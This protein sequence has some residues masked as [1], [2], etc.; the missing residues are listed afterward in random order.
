MRRVGA[1]EIGGQSWAGGEEQG[2][3][4]GS[5][6]ETTSGH[7]GLGVSGRA[8]IAAIITEGCARAPEPPPSR[9]VGCRSAGYFCIALTSHWA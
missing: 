9:R 5:Y 7:G 6:E 2:A 8:G 3:E 1:V 4:T